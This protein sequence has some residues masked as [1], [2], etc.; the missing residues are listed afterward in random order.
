VAPDTLLALVLPTHPPEITTFAPAVDGFGEAPMLRL[1]ALHGGVQQP[2]DG[3][4]PGAVLPLTQQVLGAQQGVA[5]QQ[6]GVTSGLAAP[7]LVGT[8]Q[9]GMISGADCGQR[10]RGARCAAPAGPAVPRIRAAAAATR[11]ESGT[12]ERRI[13]GGGRSRGTWD[14]R[15]PTPTA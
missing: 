8:G 4:Q 10:M 14:G 2:A 6:G 12:I 13:A 5:W 7:A 1:P 15:E 11:S 3:Q 9:Q